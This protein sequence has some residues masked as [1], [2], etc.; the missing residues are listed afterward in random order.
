MDLILQFDIEIEI[1]IE[2][3]AQNTITRPYNEVVFTDEH[4]SGTE[5]LHLKEEYFDPEV[6]DVQENRVNTFPLFLKNIQKY[7]LGNIIP[8][9]SSSKAAAKSW[10]TSAGMIF[11]DGGH[12]LESA[13]NDYNCWSKYVKKNGALV[14]HDIYEDPSEGG[15]A[16][17]ELSLIHI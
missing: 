14:I 8:I 5:E 4:H 1:E 3:A 13:F 9:I 12:S 11:I 2:I 15:Q 10:D 17:Y 7:N 16:P 6:F